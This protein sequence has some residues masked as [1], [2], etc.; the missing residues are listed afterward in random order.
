MN[1]E[2]LHGLIWENTRIQGQRIQG[3]E[4]LPDHRVYIPVA[5]DALPF[6]VH[7]CYFVTFRQASEGVWV[8]ASLRSE[9]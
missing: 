3:V 2:Q 6:R 8:I 7:R 5:Q 1:I 4:E 9:N